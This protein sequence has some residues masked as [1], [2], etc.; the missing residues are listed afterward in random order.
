MQVEVVKDLVEWAQQDKRVYLKQ[1][2]EARL[3]ALYLDNKMYTDALALIAGLLKELK[4]LDDKM[5]LVEVHLLESR[6]YWALK[7]FPKSRVRF[8]FFFY[9]HPLKSHDIL[10]LG[11][12]DI[13]TNLGQRHLLSAIDAGSAGYAI[14]NFACR[15]QGLQDCLLVFL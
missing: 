6:A 5:M 7:N 1:N 15:R 12:F 14:G 8:F 3:V 11:C 10:I 2:L 4:R 13:G 9:L